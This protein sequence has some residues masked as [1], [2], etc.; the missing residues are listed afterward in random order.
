MADYTALVEA[1]NSLVDY[2]R[3]QLTPEP[4]SKGELISLCS[5]HESENNQ[6]TVYL[7]HTEE[8]SQAGQGG[9]VPFG[10][11]EERMPPTGM[12]ANFLITA[13]SK[14]P[15]Q[16]READQY[17]MIGAVIQAVKDM[18]VLEKRYLNGSLARTEAELRLS[19]ERPNFD[20]MI[21]IWNNTSSPY[22]LS[23]VVKLSGITIDSKRVRRV[24]RV[25]DVSIDV[26]QKE[27]AAGGRA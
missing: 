16:M 5:P 24:R 20:Q 11:D 18:P 8:D 26:A 14:A 3:S 9:Y 22:K 15:V 19:V 4:I 13:H 7:F 23:V 25:V 6:L 27:Q 21:K 10:R 2:L 1:G 17:R 12:T